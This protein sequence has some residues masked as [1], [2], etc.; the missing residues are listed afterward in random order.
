MNKDIVFW[1][2]AIA[3]ILILVMV[4]D[5]TKIVN[6]VGTEDEID[7]IELFDSTDADLDAADAKMEEELRFAQ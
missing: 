3:L 1:V 2:I 6:R 4:L 7:R 5:F